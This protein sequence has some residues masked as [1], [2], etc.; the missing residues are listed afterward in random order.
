[1]TPT[2]CLHGLHVEERSNSEKSSHSEDSYNY[3]GV[4]ATFHPHFGFGCQYNLDVKADS[5]CSGSD[6]DELDTALSRNNFFNH[7]KRLITR[8]LEA[9]QDPAHSI[10]RAELE[11]KVTTSPSP[12]SPPTC[13]T[14]FLRGILSGPVALSSIH[15]ELEPQVA[16]PGLLKITVPG[17]LP[18]SP[19]DSGVS[20]VDSSSGNDDGKTNISSQSSVAPHHGTAP[21]SRN[22]GTVLTPS[23]THYYRNPAYVSPISQG[24]PDFANLHHLYQDSKHRFSQLPLQQAYIPY[25]PL[26]STSLPSSPKVYTPT[27]PRPQLTTVTTQDIQTNGPDVSPGRE[28]DDFLMPEYGQSE[29]LNSENFQKRKKTKR[30]KSPID[31]CATKRRH[32]D[33]G[34]TTYLWEF[35]LKLLQDKECCPKFIKWTNREKGVFKLVDSKAVSRLWGLHKNKPDMNYET[36]GRA[37]RY[38]YQRGILAKVDGQRLVY[39]FVDVPRDIVEIDCS[40]VC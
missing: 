40:G 28:V 38:Y 3:T 24:H 14:D 25:S 23:V 22:V 31:G 4:F 16:L 26:A 5:K 20:D 37:L 13:V 32:K 33:A 15:G 35:L 18:P 7:K 11:A 36:M 27:T 17:S 29:Y 6:S 30:S 10:L 1:M 12:G 2:W 39:Q 34:N 8:Y 9:N 19:A 21:G